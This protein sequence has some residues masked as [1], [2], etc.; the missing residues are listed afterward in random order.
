MEGP[1]NIIDEDLYDTVGKNFPGTI[2]K[3]EPET[4]EKTMDI[5]DC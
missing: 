2:S 1:E 5:F 3:P 4:T